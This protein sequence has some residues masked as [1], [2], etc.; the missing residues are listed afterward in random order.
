M[1]QLDSFPAFYGTRRFFTTFT[2]A[3]HLSQSRARPIQS[4]SPHPTSQR[5]S[6]IFI[7]SIHLCL[8]LPSG[9]FP[10]GLPTSNLYAFLFSPHS[11]YMPRSSH[12]PWLHHSNYAWRRVQI[13]KLLTMP[14][15]SPSRHFIL[16]RSMF[17]PALNGW[18]WS[19][20]CIYATFLPL[21][22]SPSST[23][24]SPGIIG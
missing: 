20:W 3:L 16:L 6:Y 23:P 19:A 10:S 22:A 24:L 13:M 11:S 12:S 9:H 15:T 1:K 2:R 18:Q 5:Y 14:F 7:L 4:T 17:L 21:P 8:G